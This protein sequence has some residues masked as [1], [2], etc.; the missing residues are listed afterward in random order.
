MRSIERRGQPG[1]GEAEV[2]RRGTQGI[3]CERRG[4]LSTCITVM[5]CPFVLA[6]IRIRKAIVAFSMG[7]EDVPCQRL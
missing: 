5:P 4:L 7:A 2:D 3:S 6:R 1:G